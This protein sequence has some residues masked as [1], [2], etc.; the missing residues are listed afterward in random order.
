MPI[1]HSISFDNGIQLP[2]GFIIVTNCN[3][4]FIDPQQCEVYV[5]VYKDQTSYND[6]KPEVAHLLHVCNGEDFVDFF[7][8]VLLGVV[9]KTP[10]GQAELWLLTL[11]NYI[12]GTQ[13]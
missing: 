11:Q 3:F 5:N 9:N 13:L 10:I 4:K 8:D 6:G 1:Q 2:T 7:N 12:G